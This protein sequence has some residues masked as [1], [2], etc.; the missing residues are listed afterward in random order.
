MGFDFVYK[1]NLQIP[2]TPEKFC[3]IMSQ[4]YIGFHVKYLLF[5]ADF[6]QTY[7]SSAPFRTKEYKM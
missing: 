2:S 7:I 6:N 3:H 5:L 4:I 1:F